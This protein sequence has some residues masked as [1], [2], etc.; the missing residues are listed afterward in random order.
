MANFLR[1]AKRHKER[2]DHYHAHAGTAGYSQ[3]VPYQQRLTV[4]L[5][6]AQRSKQGKNDVALIQAII[7]DVRLKM[8]EMEKLANKDDDQE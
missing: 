7:E 8:E 5:D 4:L 6:R 3:A 1:D 2:I